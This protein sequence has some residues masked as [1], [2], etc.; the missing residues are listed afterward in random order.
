MSNDSSLVPAVCGGSMPIARM[1]ALYKLT[2]VEK[3]M[4]KYLRPARRGGCHAKARVAWL[5]WKGH[6][7]PRDPA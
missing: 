4:D 7:T 1:R 3:R 5:Y 6:S 2:D